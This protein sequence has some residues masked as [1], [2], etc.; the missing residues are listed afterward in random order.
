MDGRPK[1]GA[2]APR[3]VPRKFENN[4]RGAPCKNPP[5]LSTAGP[6]HDDALARLAASVQRPPASLSAFSGLAPEQ[7]KLL[8]DS[9]EST[10]A[11]RQQ[12]ID[13]ELAR[14]LPELPGPTVVKLLRGP[15]FAPLRQAVLRRQAGA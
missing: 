10:A 11:R 8:T 9:I 15:G 7:L 13:A 2:P 3:I 12:Q 5:G 1:R 6:N 4:I 14:A